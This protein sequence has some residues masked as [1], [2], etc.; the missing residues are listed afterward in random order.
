MF[1]LLS[2]SLVDVGLGVG[3]P[4]AVVAF[5]LDVQ[6]MVFF[7]SSGLQLGNMTSGSD[8][9]VS[10]R[11]VFLQCFCRDGDRRWIEEDNEFLLE[12]SCDQFK[13]LHDVLSVS[14]SNRMLCN[15]LL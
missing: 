9:L 10:H 4:G 2:E 1:T 15:N 6:N 8:L 7:F 14:N 12:S 11:Q 3:F 5:V 13:T